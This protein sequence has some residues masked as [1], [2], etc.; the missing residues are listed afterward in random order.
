MGHWMP[1]DAPASVCHLS[2]LTAAVYN[3]GVSELELLE[4]DAE[5]YISAA[6]GLLPYTVTWTL[7]LL[8]KPTCIRRWSSSMTCMINGIVSPLL[9][10]S[11]CVP[12][13]VIWRVAY[14]AIGGMPR[15]W[16]DRAGGLRRDRGR[17]S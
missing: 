8:Q 15:P 6:L 4:P 9:M 10:H 3:F 1:N 5:T 2:R 16:S 11:F 13:Q 12:H 7:V 14:A 17:C